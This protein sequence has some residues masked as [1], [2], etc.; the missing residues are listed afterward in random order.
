MFCAFYIVIIELLFIVFSTPIEHNDVM[1]SAPREPPRKH[2]SVFRAGAIEMRR[3][4][5]PQSCEESVGHFIIL[6][7]IQYYAALHPLNK[8]KLVLRA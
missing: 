7:D 3:R 5:T 6:I 2:E 4:A 1:F 8:Q